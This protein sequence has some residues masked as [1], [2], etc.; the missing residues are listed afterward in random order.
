MKTEEINKYLIK[1]DSFIQNEVKKRVKPKEHQIFQLDDIIQETRIFLFK[2]IQERFDPSIA[3]IDVF[4]TTHTPYSVYKAITY[5][6][7]TLYYTGKYDEG[8]GRKEPRPG[9]KKVDDLTM[10]VDFLDF[11]PAYSMDSSKSLNYPIHYI[12]ISGTYIPFDLLSKIE[13]CSDIMEAFT[14]IDAEREA[15]ENIDVE[16]I[17]R[18]VRKRLTE[19]QEEIFNLLVMEGENSQFLVRGRPVKE[20]QTKYLTA[21]EAAETLGYKGNWTIHAQVGVIRDITLQV[22]K[23]LDIK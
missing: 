22:L 16:I 15:T 3:T 23:E 2:L 18:E 13:G 20:K 9:T 1:Y 21:S 17:K 5:I 8:E 7:R 6:T 19:E 14:P 10:H 12:L 4:I 11:E